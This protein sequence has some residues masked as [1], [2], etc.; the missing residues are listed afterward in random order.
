LAAT[1]ELDRLTDFVRR[2]EEEAF[3]AAYVTDPLLSEDQNGNYVLGG[4]LT[5]YGSTLSPPTVAT[6][7]GPPMSGEEL[8]AQAAAA[9]AA[10]DYEQ[11]LSFLLRLKQAEPN[12]SDV[13]QLLYN[14]YVAYG[15][16]LLA[17]GNALSAREQCGAASTINPNGPEALN[18]LLAVSQR[19][20][21]TP[22]TP[23]PPGPIAANQTPGAVTSPAAGTAS[24]TPTVAAEL[25]PTSV[26]TVAPPPTRTQP[27]A[28]P[29]VQPTQ[30]PAP[31]QAPPATFTALPTVAGTP[32]PSVTV[33]ASPTEGPS[34]TATLY[35]TPNPN[36]FGAMGT[37]YQPNCGL[38]QIKGTVRDSGGTAVNGV[39]IR[40]WY[41]GAQPNEIYS[42][43]SGGD[44]KRG[45]GE[46]DVVLANYPKP[47]T[48]YIAV[49]DRNTG[50]VLSDVVT[51][52]TDDGPCKPG[53]SGR[54]IVTQDFLK[55]GIVAGTPVSASPT[56]VSGTPAPSATAT[57][58]PTAT[59]TVSP[60]ATVLPILYLKDETPNKLIPDGPGG[61]ITSTII[62]TDQL[63]IRELRVFPNIEHQDVGDLQ[64]DIIH[65]DGTRI[66]IHKQ[67]DS[68]GSTSLRRWF[69]ITGAALSLVKGKSAVG[70]WTLEI[71]DTIE[72]KTGSLYSWSLEIY[73]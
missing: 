17:Q 21:L 61:V 37:F 6:P 71:K 55:F 46:W 66:R 14:A 27:P 20:Q 32:S 49:V 26:P 58:T 59:A 45:P 64:I 70:T 25:T 54:Q 2:L 51:A 72:G 38:T 57:A 24:E 69:D 60:S 39:T 10:Q 65:P 9:L 41:D 11:A 50:A 47:G 34:P 28:P 53:E 15:Q 18:C 40:V 29:P 43:P 4:T 8:R 19:I 36:P 16:A 44:I 56:T 63:T 31:T 68:P 33:A 30:P 1:G 48:W 12:A 52:I 3:P 35:V 73:P 22:T 23:T 67:G 7:A 5:V 42:L 13:D 62:I